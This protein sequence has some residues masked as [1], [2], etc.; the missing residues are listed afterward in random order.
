MG[1]D[2][3]SPDVPS[4]RLA[5]TSGHDAFEARR[6]RLVLIR[7]GWVHARRDEVGRS[8]IARPDAGT[9]RRAA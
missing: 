5:D 3:L 9:G 4:S 6:L 2:R 1:I 8:E 7:P